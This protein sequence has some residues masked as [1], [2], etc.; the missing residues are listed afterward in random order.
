MH[1]SDADALPRAR[2]RPGDAPKTDWRGAMRKRHRAHGGWPIG[3]IPLL[4]AARAARLGHPRTADPEDQEQDWAQRP[5]PVRLR[6]EI[7]ALLRGADDKLNSG[8][9]HKKFADRLL[10]GSLC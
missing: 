4:P 9:F 3:G 2:P 1:D 8:W 7:Q 6:K 10:D 5:V